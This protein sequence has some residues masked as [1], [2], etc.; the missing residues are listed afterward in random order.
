MGMH[1][2]MSTHV[3][4]CAFTHR[5]HRLMLGVFFNRSQSFPFLLL[6]IFL[7]FIEERERE[8]MR[9]VRHVKVRGQPMEMGSSPSTM[10]ILGIEFM[11]SS[12]VASAFNPLIAL[13]SPPHCLRQNV[14]LS[15]EC[16]G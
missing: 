9:L 5:S 4:M 6:K 16:T 8:T 7:R 15:L 2:C 3:H 12:L 1:V 14:S 11:S 13:S 10:R